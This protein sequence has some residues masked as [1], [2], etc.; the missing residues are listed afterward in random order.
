MGSDRTM[1]RRFFV[2]YDYG[3]GDLWAFVDAHSE[4]EIAAAFPEL[5]VFDPKPPEVSDERFRELLEFSETRFGDIDDEGF[6]LF[7]AL[8][9]GRSGS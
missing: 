3:Q 5:R 9:A 1:K 7:E 8:R 4:A 6:W 2:T